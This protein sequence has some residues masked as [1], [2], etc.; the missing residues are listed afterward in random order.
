MMIVPGSGR[1]GQVIDRLESSARISCALMSIRRFI[2]L[3]NL[4]ALVLLAGSIATVLWLRQVSG[5]DPFSREGLAALAERLGP[6]GPIAF[7][8][9]IALAVVVSQIPGVPLAVAAGALWG[10]LPAALYSIAGGFLGGMIAYFLGRTLGRNAM[11]ALTG[12]VVVFSRE[13]GE[14]YLGWIILVSRLLPVLSFDVISYAAGLSGLSVRIYAVATLV[15][16]TP[17]TLLLTFLGSRLALRA[18]IALGLSGIALVVLLALPWL[19]KRFGWFDGVIR[20]EERG[21]AGKQA[22]PAVGE[23]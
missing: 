1:F 2:T 21:I 4:V 23:G 13:R 19:S 11:L 5:A 15:G 17:S 3:P 20:F 22:P 8:L 7:A 10:A 18:E 9:L 14:I 6:W 12:R 16:M